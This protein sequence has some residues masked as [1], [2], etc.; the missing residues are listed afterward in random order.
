MLT[1]RQL[2][3]HRMLQDKVPIQIWIPR[4]L[5]SAVKTAADKELTTMSEYVRRAL[6]DRV[7]ADGVEIDRKEFILQTVKWAK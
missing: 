3:R 4:A 5:D 7:R 1:P 2:K 6:I